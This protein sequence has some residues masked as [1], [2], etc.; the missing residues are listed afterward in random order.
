MRGTLLDCH[1]G[2]AEPVPNAT[3][4]FYAPSEFAEFLAQGRD[5]HVNGAAGEDDIA[6][7]HRCDDLI[8]RSDET[9]ALRQVIQDAELGD[10]QFNDAAIDADHMA[11]GID[12]Q[13]AIKSLQAVVITGV[14][15]V[16]FA[17]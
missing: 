2:L 12:H 9:R 13:S 10:R 5:V 8:A 7:V 4:G 14:L 15:L 11:I 6:A 17:T 3:D 1:Q 16:E